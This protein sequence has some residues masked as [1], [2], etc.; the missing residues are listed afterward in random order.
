MNGQSTRIPLDR[1]KIEFID[2]GKKVELGND[3]MDKSD[4]GRHNNTSSKRNVK[5]QHIRPTTAVQGIN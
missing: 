1:D 2:D 5:R 4:Q 3:E